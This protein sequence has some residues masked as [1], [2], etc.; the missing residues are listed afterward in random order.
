M[1]TR[2]TGIWPLGL[3]SLAALIALLML[4]W[5]NMVERT[6]FLGIAD[7]KEIIINSENPVEVEKV[8]VMEGQSVERGQLLVQLRNP[9]LTLKINQIAHQLDQYRAQNDVDKNELQS[10]LT[11]LEAEKKALIDETNYQ[12]QE[13]KNEYDLNMS[14]ASRLQSISSKSLINNSNKSEH[15]T[16]QRIERLK[17]ELAST[18]QVYDVR[19]ELQKKAIAEADKPVS[20]QINKLEKELVMLSA[21]SEK[22]AKYAPISGMIGSVNFKAGEKISPFAAVMT[23]HTKTPS[24]VK[25]YLREDEYSKV[26]VDDRLLIHPTT[27]EQ[28]QVEGIVVGVGSRIVEYPVRLQKYQDM[29]GWGREITIK[30]P[31]NNNLILGEKVLVSTN[32]NSKSR[33]QRF[34]AYLFPTETIAAIVPQK[35]RDKSKPAS[36]PVSIVRPI[37][38]IDQ[39]NLEASAI[40][41]LPDMEQFLVASDDTPNKHFIL[42]LMNQS[43]KITREITIPGIDKI[44]DIESMTRDDD[45]TIYIATSM[46]AKKDKTNPVSRRLLVA[47]KQDTD[48]SFY[49]YK[50][51][52]LSNILTRC[53]LKNQNAPWAGFILNAVQKNDL[54][55]EAMFWHDNALFLGFKS[56]LFMKR[57]II[58]KILNANRMLDQQRLEGSQVAIWQMLDLISDEDNIRERISDLLFLDGSLYITGVVDADKRQQYTGSLWHFFID[59]GTL[60]R[61][62]K[63]KDLKPEGIA[64]TDK[65]T[66]LMVCFD[67]G[68]KRQSHIARIKDIR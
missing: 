42:Y 44:D 30:I 57:S 67:Q 58:I 56:P 13:L 32:A 37:L 49:L 1:N 33:W 4:G 41:Y 5:F 52:D 39:R 14:L 24:I 10:A 18:V 35:K 65:A 45:A 19:I 22:L 66:D 3:A 63:F 31:E 62:T 28:N 47:I 55:M 17:L 23:L 68:S 50:S 60:Q 51:I 59:D 26:R 27:D 43:G 7:S 25:G 46:S 12:I 11:Q 54:D 48:K 40:L 29:K 16:I 6:E 15:P 64:V 53:A 20:I 36:E 21:E 34:Q 9:E 38:S 2:I 61:I 8:Y